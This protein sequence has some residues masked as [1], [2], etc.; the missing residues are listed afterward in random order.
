ME[1][2]MTMHLERG[3]STLSTRKRVTKLQDRSVYEAEMVQYNKQARRDNLPQLQFKSLDDYI[4]YRHG[5]GKKV[6][7]T[8]KPMKQTALPTRFIRQTKVYES[9]VS[10][11]GSTSKV[12]PTMYSGNYMIGI[13]TMHKSNLV[14]VTRDGN[15]AEYSTMRRS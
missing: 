2:S 7:S 14:P 11:N 12:E 15:P 6:S 10:T 1:L 4:A 3:L 5:T 13:A 9:K 8:F